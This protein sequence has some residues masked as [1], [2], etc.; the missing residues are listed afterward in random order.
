MFMIILQKDADSDADADTAQMI[1]RALLSFSFGIST[2]A[3][4]SKITGVIYSK[5][6]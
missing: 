6:A 3:I 4:G 2:V 1:G 5:G